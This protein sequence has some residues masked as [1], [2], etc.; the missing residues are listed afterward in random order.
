M[1]K[2]KNQQLKDDNKFVFF[3]NID[4]KIVSTVHV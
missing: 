2:L 3:I 4:E 1:L